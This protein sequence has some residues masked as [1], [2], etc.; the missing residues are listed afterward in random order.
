VAI[1]K[2]WD[3]N[4]YVGYRKV[5]SDSVV[6]GFADADFGLGGTN[7]KGETIGGSLAVSNG[8]WF[9]LKWMPAA[10][11]AG[12]TYKINIIQLDVNSKF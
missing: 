4:A 7:F 11:I 1:D 10:V 12:P 5:G 3:W 6:D 8:V 9:E 2:A